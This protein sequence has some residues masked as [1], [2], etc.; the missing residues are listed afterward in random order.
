MF[1]S[2]R[3]NNFFVIAITLAA[4][5]LSSYRP[6][7]SGIDE[8]KKKLISQYAKC[9]IAYCHVDDVIDSIKWFYQED[10]I[11]EQT[12][13]LI[14]LRDA[15]LFLKE[16]APWR[17]NCIN[18]QLYA[19][20][21]LF[22]KGLKGS[23]ETREYQT[24]MFVLTTISWLC[25]M[26]IQK[27]F[28]QKKSSRTPHRNGFLRKRPNNFIQ[29]EIDYALNDFTQAKAEEYADIM[30]NH[31]LE[32][33]EYELYHQDSQEED[34]LY[35]ET[36]GDDHCVYI[37]QTLDFEQTGPNFYSS[38]DNESSSDSSDRSYPSDDSNDSEEPDIIKLHE[39]PE[40]LEV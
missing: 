27:K 9:D 2:L 10:T 22:L 17:I 21:R 13:T 8:K 12:L 11:T 31:Y 36:S 25:E 37:G 16:F 23:C 1:S 15:Q 32:E 5:S 38:S 40:S 18:R 20:T 14:I 33:Q 35:D 39:L 34:I 24:T 19:K 6:L 3:K 30:Y 28:S 7:S 29:E 26:Y 4:L